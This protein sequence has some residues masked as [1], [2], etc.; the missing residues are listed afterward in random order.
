MFALFALAAFAGV[1]LLAGLYLAF[2]AEDSRLA[3]REE[4]SA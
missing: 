4:Q 2:A 1:A 3:D